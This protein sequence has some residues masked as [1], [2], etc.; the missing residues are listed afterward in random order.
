MW[1]LGLSAIRSC[2]CVWYRVSDWHRS[3]KLQGSR[4]RKRSITKGILKVASFAK[5]I[6]RIIP[7]YGAKFTTRIIPVYEA[8]WC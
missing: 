6:A 2:Y 7:V 8:V 5:F 3:N 4:L 1:Q